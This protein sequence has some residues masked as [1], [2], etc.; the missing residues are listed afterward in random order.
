MDK[1]LEKIAEV[2]KKEG[3]T[4]TF[5]VGAGISTN[6]GIPD[7]RSPK[8]GLYANLQRLN[9]PYPEAVFDI[10]YFKKS[11]KAFYTL[12]DELFPGKFLPSIF[13]YF[14]K[15]CQDKG[16]LRRCY[17][18][19][20]DTLERIAGVEDDK[21]VEA[22]GSFA[23]SHCI[24]CKA[25]METKVLRKL[26]KTGIPKC[27]VCKG[28]VKP[29]IVFFGEGL[30]SKFFDL[31]DEDCDTE[32]NLAIV[33]G[34]SLAVFPFANLPHEINKNCKRVLINREK[35]GTFLDSPRKTD[36][37]LLEDCDKIAEK[38]VDLLGWK[39]ELDALI[40]KGKKKME[41][42]KKLV[43][44]SESE[45]ESEEEEADKHKGVEKAEKLSKEVAAKVAKAEEGSKEGSTRGK[46]DKDV[47]DL[48]SD[49]EKTK[50]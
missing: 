28:Y 32:K 39:T 8:T 45:S 26:M 44:E 20:I 23:N 40:A 1:K 17:S 43:E 3:S 19:N 25:E 49:L 15:L 36:I 47:V 21:I 38:L 48:A 5:F 13:H 22:H 11:P 37:I 6:C 41:T 34:T 42:E 10:E 2:L 4:V 24:T 7:F 14:I 18:Q 9:L 50:I 29:D 30:P 16:K 33:A 31:W 27:P 12:A 35:C 46:E